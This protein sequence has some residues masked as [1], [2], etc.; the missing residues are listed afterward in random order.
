MTEHRVFHIALWVKTDLNPFDVRE[1]ILDLCDEMNVEC[2]YSDPIE[3]KHEMPS[4]LYN[5]DSD[6]ARKRDE[7]SMFE[8]GRKP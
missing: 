8:C 7:Q 2:D 6:E 5:M 1:R 4:E 3:D